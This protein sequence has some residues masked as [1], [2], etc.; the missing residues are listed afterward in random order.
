MKISVHCI[1]H[2]LEADFLGTS[3]KKCSKFLPPEDISTFSSTQDL[4][5]FMNKADHILS[6]SVAVF[7]T[8]KN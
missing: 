7:N 6:T 8:E 4:K 3:E 2:Y 1:L 5:I